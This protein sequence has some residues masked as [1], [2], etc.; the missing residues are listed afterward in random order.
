MSSTERLTR[1]SIAFEVGSRVT[2]GVGVGK[3]GVISFIGET[4]FAAGEWIGLTLDNPDGKNDGSLADV[5][6]F[7]CKPLH[8]VFVKRVSTNFVVECDGRGPSSIFSELN[9]GNNILDNFNVALFRRKSSLILFRHQLSTPK[10]NS[11]LCARR[12]ELG[13]QDLLLLAYQS[14]PL[15]PTRMLVTSNRQGRCLAL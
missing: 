11:L 6:Y 8:G 5:A 1:S 14:E 3:K 13:R 15:V 7:T 4:Q 12:G 9:I 10:I 2:T